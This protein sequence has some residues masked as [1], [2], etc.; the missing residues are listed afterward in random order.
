MMTMEERKRA[1]IDHAYLL[2]LMNRVGK[3]WKGK[4]Y[5]MLFSVM[6]ETEFYYFIDNDSNRAEE[7]K[8]LRTIFA[9]E[10]SANTSD[11]EEIVNDILAGPCN[12][13]EML[14]AFAEKI[15][16]AV[17][18]NEEDGD[19]TRLWFWTMVDNLGLLEYSDDV[20][21]Q[22]FLNGVREKLVIMMDRRYSYNGEGGLFPLEHPQNDQRNVELWYQMQDFMRENY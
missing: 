11:A 20:I 7:G 21:T 2:W 6:Y 13:L 17:M 3:D 9:N 12:V 8:N 19:R 16:F 4:S 1:R 22:D 5:T 18:W 14:I 10:Y 15:D